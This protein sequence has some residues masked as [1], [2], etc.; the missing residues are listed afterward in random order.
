MNLIINLSMR[1]LPPMQEEARLSELYAYNILDTKA[2]QEF[3]DVVELASVIADTPVSL[4]TLVDDTRQWCKA[5]KG[6]ELANVS[7]EFSFCAK[8]IRS[9]KPTIVADT[10]KDRHFCHSPLV[11]GRSRVRFYA[12][13]PLISPQGYILGT[14]C[15]IDTRP[16]TLTRTQVRNLEQLARQVVK[17]FEWRL[18][19]KSLRFARRSERRQGEKLSRLLD[20]QR[21]IVAILAHDT[22]AS[23][24]SIK[25]LLQL[26]LEDKIDPGDA[27]AVY[28]TM[29][30]QADVT[31]D[32]ISNL[33][34]WGGT[35]LNLAQAK[36]IRSSMLTQLSEKVFIQ[37]KLLAQSKGIQLQQEFRQDVELPGGWAVFSFIIRNLVHNAIK[38][39]EGGT[40]K[41]AGH[42]SGDSYILSVSDQGIGMTA[43]IAR[44]L[45]TG[46]ISSR[47]GTRNEQGSALGLM[48]MHDFIRQ[49][50]GSVEVES[51]PGKG[52]GIRI[53]LPVKK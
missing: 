7:R 2:E 13:F 39:S 40:V 28:Q 6:F 44:Q 45:F 3:D 27:P 9:D 22:R 17:L 46:A 50:E 1:I 19:Q 29:I 51:R 15:V 34:Q 16:R 49:L 35:Y 26:F 53:C 52:T 47:K 8:A 10:M 21:R 41:V 23:L 12:G 33:V 42:R 43:Q 30:D 32:M 36:N 14:L 20:N 18:Q 5:R 25:S 11:T 48:L 24:I 37:Y 4:I 31:H 38:Y